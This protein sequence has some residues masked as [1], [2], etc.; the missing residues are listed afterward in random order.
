MDTNKEW[1]S[2]KEAAE[3]LGVTTARIRQ[4]VAEKQVEAQKLGGKYRGQWLIKA[5]E[6]EKRLVKLSKK[7]AYSMRVKGRMTPNPIVVSPSTSYNEALKL[8]KSNGIKHLPVLDKKG[9]TKQK[10][11]PI[12]VSVNSG[13]F[14]KLSPKGCT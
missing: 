4:M 14:L 2:T 13:L 1:I 12:H 8:M 11:C 3:R 9:R 7:G 5:S 10:P 6:I